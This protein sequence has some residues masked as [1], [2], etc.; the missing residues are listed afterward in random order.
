ML[1]LHSTI[2]VAGSSR[3]CFPYSDATTTNTITTA[4]PITSI[5]ICGPSPKKRQI[6][7]KEK[8][9]VRMICFRTK[10]IIDFTAPLIIEYL[11]DMRH[12]FLSPHM[13]DAVLSAGNYMLQLLKNRKEIMTIAVFTSFGSR[14]ISLN[15]QIY[16]I[17]SGFFSLHSFAKKRKEE[18]INAM[19]FLHTPYTH[20]DYID[21]AFRK[22]TKGTHIYPTFRKLFSGII[23]HE[24]EKHMQ[25]WRRK[26]MSF[27]KK[28]DIIY[29]PLGIGNHADHIIVNRI[30]QT[31]PNK[32]YFWLDQPYA[33]DKNIYQHKGYQ[34]VFRIPHQIKKESLQNEYRSQIKLIY[35]RRIPTIDEVF[36]EKNK[37]NNR[38]LNTPNIISF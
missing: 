20:L 35:S 5:N 31:L 13:D 7:R 27:C 24:D 34:E 38:N 16:L 21:G 12:I 25:T 6:K 26:I 37:S 9:V 29:A 10:S 11:H 2:N 28:T 3:S 15:A 36:F 14:P 32:I 33:H 19:R 22:T 17:K 1:A 23:T 18:D 4:A 30:A 8:K